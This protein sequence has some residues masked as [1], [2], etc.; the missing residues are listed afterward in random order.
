MVTQSMGPGPTAGYAMA[1]AA[2][3]ARTANAD[4]QLADLRAAADRLTTT[5]PT[6][7]SIR[8]VT[9]RATSAAEAAVAAGH[10]AEAAVVGAMAAYWDDLEDRLAQVGAAG[11]GLIDDGDVVLTHCWADAPLMAILEAVLARGV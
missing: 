10:D 8:L 1:I 3:A 9:A 11:A 7:D 2:R 4:R 6:N 5:R